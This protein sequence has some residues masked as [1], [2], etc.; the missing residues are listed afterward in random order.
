MEILRKSMFRS[1]CDECRNPFP[2]N[3]GG[4]CERCRR[5]L[6]NEHLHGSF[7]R[8]I[9]IAFGAPYVCVACRAG[10]TPTPR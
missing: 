5:I 10:Q 6:C 2:V 1:D 4:V 8:R 9:A 7:V 3:S